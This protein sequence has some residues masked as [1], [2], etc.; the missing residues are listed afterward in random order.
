MKLTVDQIASSSGSLCCGVRVEYSDNG[1]VRFAQVEIPWSL[2]TPE[3]VDHLVK[4]TG[5]IFNAY[6]DTDPLF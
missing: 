5:R 6:L 3:V 4:H 2:F 1:P